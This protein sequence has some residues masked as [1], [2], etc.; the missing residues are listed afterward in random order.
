[1][2]KTYRSFLVEF[3]LCFGYWRKLADIDFKL[4]NVQ[5]GLKVYEEA[6]VAIPNCIDL[7]NFYVAL[8]VERIGNPQDVRPSDPL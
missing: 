8:V 3:P 7:W 1:M 4:G 6:I 2:Q 5:D